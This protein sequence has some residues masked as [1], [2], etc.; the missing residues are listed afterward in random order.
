M[1]QT[2]ELEGS[3]GPL[4]S[5]LHIIQMGRLRPREEEGYGGRQGQL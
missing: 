5:C 3:W 1:P 4:Q 2:V